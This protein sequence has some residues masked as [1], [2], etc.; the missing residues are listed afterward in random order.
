MFWKLSQS[1]PEKKMPFHWKKTLLDEVDMWDKTVPQE[2]CE[3]SFA[4]TI[5]E[6]SDQMKP[7]ND[8][9]RVRGW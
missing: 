4:S 5:S 9:N 7:K 6:Q 2:K 1:S 3:S 8:E